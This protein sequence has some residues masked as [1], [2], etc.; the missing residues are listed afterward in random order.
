MTV[1]GASKFSVDRTGAIIALGA[2]SV[3]SLTINSQTP[4]TQN[5]KGVANGYAGLDTNGDLSGYRL[6]VRQET[7][8][9]EATIVLANGE[10]C[11][12]TDAPANVYI[13]DGSTAGGLLLS[14]LLYVNGA[15]GTAGSGHAGGA[16]GTISP[17]FATLT[18]SNGGAGSSGTGVP[19][20]GGTLSSSVITVTL[21]R[22]GDANASIAG[23]NGGSITVVP[24]RFITGNGSTG[25]T[26]SGGLSGNITVGMLFQSG[27]GGA[28]GSGSNSTGGIGGNVSVGVQIVG[29]AG[30]AGGSVQYSPRRFWW[31]CW[32]FT[33]EWG[34][35]WFWRCFSRNIGW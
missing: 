22:G 15:V 32:R 19:G 2:M 13:G 8:A 26:V 12:T 5:N 27:A 10:L 21:G 23:Q 29:G 17:T 18:A 31:K 1:G 30:G 16:A 28:G 24:I 20:N 9:N 34:C 6:I 35:W 33:S 4:E 3:P 25:G 14:H 7:I 11:Q